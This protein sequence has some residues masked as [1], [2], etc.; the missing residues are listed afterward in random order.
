MCG[1]CHTVASPL[2]SHLPSQAPAENGTADIGVIMTAELT[3]EEIGA[4]KMES[5][6]YWE[7]AWFKPADLLLDES[8]HPVRRCRLKPMLKR[9]VLALETKL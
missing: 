4:M 8:L 2:T 9:L 3:D 7:F 6:E 1:C 5:A